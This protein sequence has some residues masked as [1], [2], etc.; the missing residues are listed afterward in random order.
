MNILFFIN[1]FGGLALFLFAMKI[2]SDNLHAVAG[3]E[4]KRFIKKLTNTPIKGV[5]VGMIVTGIVQSSSATTVMLIGLV[6]AGIMSLSQAVGVIM[7]ANIGTTVTA[8]LIA[9][10]LGHYA[11]SFV[12]IG[13]LMLF[14]KRSKVMERWSLIT[15]GFGL[16][17][18]AL[19]IMSDS[20]IPLREAPAIR[21]A[22]VSL[23]NNPLLAILAGTIF[24]ML[25]QSSS[26]AIG[27]VIVLAVNNLIPIEG[28]MYLVFGDN[29]GTTITAW[30]ASISVNKTARRV[31]LVHSMFNIVGTII[32]TLL[33]YFG[34]YTH[35]VNILT[36]GDIFN[37]GSIARFIANTHTYFNIIN[38]L[39]F[40]PF[41][42]LLADIA[43]KIIKKDNNETLSSGEPRHL[44][45]HLIQTADLAVE[46]TIKEMREMLKLVRRSLEI[47][48]D[49]YLNKNY[50][51]QEKIHKL[52]NAIDHLQKEITLYLV[53][54]NEQTNSQDIAKKIPSLLHTVND[55]EKLGDHAE[56]VNE[57]LNNQILSQKESFYPEFLSILAENHKKIIYM[58]DLTLKYMEELDQ[59]YTYKIIELEGRINQQ[60]SDL[61]KRI[62]CMIQNAECDAASG[63]N[64][65][66]YIDTIEF[67][68]DKLKNIVKAGS[69]HFIYLHQPKPSS[70]RIL[71][72][73]DNDN[74][75]QDY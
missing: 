6:N 17:F 42:K 63:L 11:F 75:N 73:D 64:T 19:N 51:K 67:L 47:S 50:R 16:L 18:I 9:F 72:D 59:D 15:L 43:Y 12:I 38:C 36:P 57:I 23:S 62:I 74:S 28:A 45:Y 44:D 56:Q 53:A 58:I 20:V 29:I 65:I 68:A 26:A 60:H 49:S 69:H 4:M 13:V 31:A 8:Q 3:N 5:F 25:I 1:F 27:I 71:P 70:E 2:M 66:D 14:A 61:R 54:V 35:F 37:G 52:E 21:E 40:L 32:F 48:M 41:S 33:T 34:Y 46:Q 10:K 39:I 55:I 22:L 24:T 7:G 30:L